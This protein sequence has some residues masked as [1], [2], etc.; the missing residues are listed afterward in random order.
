MFVLAF[1]RS[2]GFSI[3]TSDAENSILPL[4][5][6]NLIYRH[7][8]IAGCNS[9]VQNISVNNVTP[10]IIFFNER[11]PGYQPHC[12]GDSINVTAI[13]LCE[14]RVM[15]A[16]NA[17]YSRIIV[18]KNGENVHFYLKWF[19]IRIYGDASLSSY[20]YLIS[21]IRVWSFLNAICIFYYLMF[22][23]VQILLVSMKYA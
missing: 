20:V 13:E 22:S 7:E 10:G 16:Y 4:N 8:L 19:V 1:K 6:E 11:H 9:P 21:A 17:A 23:T 5:S 12:E 15:G 3:Y 14:V 18:T 2:S